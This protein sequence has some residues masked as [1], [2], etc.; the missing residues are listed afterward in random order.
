MTDFRICNKWY[1]H[2]AFLLW[3]KCLCLPSLQNSYV[4]A[5]YPDKVE[6][7]RSTYV[8]MRYE[9]GA[10]MVGSAPLWGEKDRGP[11]LHWGG[12]KTATCGPERGPSPETDC[13]GPSSLPIPRARG[14]EPQPGE[15]CDVGPSWLQPSASPGSSTHVTLGLTQCILDSFAWTDTQCTIIDSLSWW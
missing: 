5:Q 14:R 1:I 15:L 10:S 12:Q 6:T 9:G 7:L 11:S 4:E 2:V 3:N 13:A 8:E